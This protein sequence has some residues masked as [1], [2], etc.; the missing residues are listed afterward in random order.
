MVVGRV[1]GAI[2]AVAL[3]AFTLLLVVVGR[4]PAL[5]GN[6]PVEESGLDL[7][8]TRDFTGQSTD[9]KLFR[10][11][12]G[13]LVVPGYEVDQEAG[14]IEPVDPE[15]VEADLGLDAV[16]GTPSSSTSSPSTTTEEQKKLERGTAEPGSSLQDP[17]SEAQREAQ[18]ALGESTSS[19]TDPELEDDTDTEP[20]PSSGS[21][22]STTSTT[23]TGNDGSQYLEESTTTT[24]P[25]SPTTEKLVD[26]GAD[27]RNL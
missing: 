26:Q 5:E 15:Q 1:V 23:D 14:T 11:Q 13:E 4:E 24:D 12:S 22:S 3:L 10:N 20:I 16:S 27:F 2:A 17:T 19:P 9:V 8:E 7:S 6:V 21:T 18:K 25:T